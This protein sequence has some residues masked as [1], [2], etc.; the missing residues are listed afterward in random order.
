[1]CIDSTSV[2][3]CLRGN[4]SDSS[5]W[6]FHL[7]QDA[8]QTRDIRIKWSPGHMDIEGNEEAD[9]LADIA[10]DPASP[11]WIDDPIAL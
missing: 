8:M 9:A 6:A 10:A 11:K 3:W 2:I 7:C 4:A 5:Q 1:M